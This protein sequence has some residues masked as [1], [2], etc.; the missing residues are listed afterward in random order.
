DPLVSNPNRYVKINIHSQ[1]D[2][3]FVCAVETRRVRGRKKRTSSNY[4]VYPISKVDYLNVV[5]QFVAL[6][7]YDVLSRLIDDIYLLTD[8]GLVR[9]GV[10]SIDG[11]KLTFNITTMRSNEKTKPFYSLCKEILSLAK[12]KPGKY[13][14]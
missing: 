11:K 10:T 6:Q 9:L 2:T 1:S 14:K 3:S 12:L 7:T 13:L 8:P 5:N 4:A